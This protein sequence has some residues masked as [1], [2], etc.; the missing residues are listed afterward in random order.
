MQKLVSD[1]EDILM[2]N[3]TCKDCLNC[4][5]NDEYCVYHQKLF[6]LPRMLMERSITLEKENEAMKTRNEV[7]AI[8]IQKFRASR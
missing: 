1:A 2:E 5:E 3:S 4:A 7:R 6:A 8:A